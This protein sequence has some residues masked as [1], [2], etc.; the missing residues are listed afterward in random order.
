MK[1]LLRALIVYLRVECYVVTPIKRNHQK[2]ENSVIF[3][4]GHVNLD[5]IFFFL[6]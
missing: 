2:R 1:W 6:C 5:Y 3:Y 4:I